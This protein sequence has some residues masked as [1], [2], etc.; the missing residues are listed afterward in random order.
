MPAVGC[1][2][3]EDNEIRNQQRQ[4]KGIDLVQT[5]KSFIQKMLAQ[6]GSQAFGGEDYDHGQRGSERQVHEVSRAVRQ[7]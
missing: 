4:I 7:E 5:L 2:D 6:V 1:Q 3:D